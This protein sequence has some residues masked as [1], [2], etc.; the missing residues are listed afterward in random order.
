MF[1]NIKKRI[2]AHNTTPSHAAV[3]L[4][5]QGDVYIGEERYE[6]AIEC[7][8]QAIKLSPHFSEALVA[9]G[10]AL[11]ETGAVEQAEKCL[12]QA[13]S[14]TPN[15]VDAYFMLGNIAKI[16]GDLRQATEHYI[17]A[18]NIN[19]Q[20]EFAY[21]MLFE[22]YQA[23]GNAALA[24]TLL[25]RAM[26]AFPSAVNF[27]FER[28][29]VAFA[30]KDYQKA[31]TLLEKTLSLEPA[32]IASHSNLAKIYMQLGQDEAAIPHLEQLTHINPNDAALHEDLG[33]LYLKL[34]RK[35]DALASFKEVVRIEPDSPLTHLVAALSGTTT[36]TAPVAYAEMLFDHY[37]E[38]FEAHLTQTLHYHTP[39]LLV[40]LIDSEVNLAGRKLE[41]LD[42]GCGTGLFGKAISSHASR[43]VG[44][45]ISTKM[46]EKA[47]QLNLYH[48]LEHTD[49]L[50][51]MKKEPDASYDL[52]AATDVFIYLGALDELVVEAKRLLRP[53]GIFA[54]STECLPESASLA[55]H[56][57]F[58]LNDTG[59]YTHAISYLNK[60]ANDAEF[61][62]LETKEAII[63]ENDGKPVIGHL[64]LWLVDAE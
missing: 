29:G 21:R 46:L 61:N 58:E 32:H 9:L 55:K 10:F 23:Q 56:Q 1:A 50:A 27:I 15:S 13:L 54:F 14:I 41:V 51:M 18:T 52:I 43:I 40:S 8:Q 17:R 53:N 47:A 7:Y 20:F 48:R 31:I 25:E 30:E 60:L 24:K 3:D 11:L 26:L 49:I 37:A 2:N 45:D 35:L 63:R 64:S 34:G 62:I 42:L 5:K 39:T 22:V 38:N 19:P 33:N 16:K 59:R 6:Q 36:T 12:Q 57:G 28:A 4:K 44:V